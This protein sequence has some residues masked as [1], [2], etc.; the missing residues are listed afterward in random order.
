MAATISSAQCLYEFRYL[1]VGQAFAA[2]RTAGA[3]VA[4]RYEAQSYK[5]ENEAMI[6][7]AGIEDIC[8]PQRSRAGI[9]HNKFI[10]LIHKGVPIA[11]WTGSTNISAGG[12]FGHS[13]VGH[14]IWDSTI[15]TRF[16]AYWQ[17]LASPTLSRSFSRID[18][19]Q[20]A[21]HSRSLGVTNRASRA[22]P[23]RKP[24]AASARGLTASQRC[25]SSGAAEIRV[26]VGHKRQA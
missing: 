17:A 10:V 24:A 26:K 3:D 13:N 16:L 15:A 5:D 25:S 14:A 4:I 6:T 21:S 8:Q 19:N 9:R 22:Q 11:V 2:A 7:E 23:V 20:R 18:R 1:P 12:I